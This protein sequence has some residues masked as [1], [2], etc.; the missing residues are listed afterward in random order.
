MDNIIKQ[1]F[2]SL[3][4]AVMYQLFETSNSQ[5]L[6][7]SHIAGVRPRGFTSSAFFLGMYAG[8]GKPDKSLQK[9]HFHLQYPISHCGQLGNRVHGSADKT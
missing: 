7:V 4:I 8:N 9:L 6:T 3:L 5:T 2:K 1:L